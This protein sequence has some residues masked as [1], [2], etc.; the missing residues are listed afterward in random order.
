MVGVLDALGPNWTV[1]HGVSAD[2]EL[3]TVEHL[4]V[5]PPGVVAIGIHNHRGGTVWVGERT[6]I[7]DGEAQ[8]GLAVAEAQ[9]RAVEQRMSRALG[10]PMGVVPCLL[11]VDPL[12]LEAR[13]RSRDTVVLRSA[14]LRGW[15]ARLPRLHSQAVVDRCSTAAAD[16]GTWATSDSY[17]PGADLAGFARI[18]AELTCS[19]R[20]RLAWAVSAAVLTQASVVAMY[21]SVLEESLAGG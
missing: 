17:E 9:R 13:A 4:L 10:S 21:A 16:P 2:P 5:G 19:R 14:Q 12:E 20:R 8:P 7:V 6:M 1:L 11:I 3:P 18:D 15:L